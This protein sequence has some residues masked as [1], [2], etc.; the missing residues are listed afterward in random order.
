[1]SL[2]NE[3]GWKKEEIISISILETEKLQFLASNF[4]SNSISRI[5]ICFRNREIKLRYQT[6]FCSK[7]V[8]ENKKIE[9]SRNINFIMR[10]LNDYTMIWC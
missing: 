3:E 1:M 4:Y 7:L 5:E 10:S 6:D 8:P 2:L 9:K